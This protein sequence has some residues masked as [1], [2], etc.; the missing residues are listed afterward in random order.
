MINLSGSLRY[1]MHGRKRK[2]KTKPSAVRAKK[3]D[4]KPMEVSPTEIARSRATDAH[5]EKYPSADIGMQ[6]ADSASA[7]TSWKVKESKNFTV[8]PAY[9]KGAY[10]VIGKS[11]VRDIGR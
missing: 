10:Q 9:N 6:R 8:A 4:F 3:T 11:S 1:D 5:R 7:D 2:S